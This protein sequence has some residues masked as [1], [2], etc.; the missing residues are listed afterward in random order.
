[1][2]ANLHVTRPIEIAEPVA[3]RKR[4]TSLFAM[5]KKR[6]EELAPV[7]KTALI[8][9]VVGAP[10]GYLVERAAGQRSRAHLRVT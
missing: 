3:E 8:S 2:S 10:P 1:V 9:L 4:G 7:E 6:E 5:T